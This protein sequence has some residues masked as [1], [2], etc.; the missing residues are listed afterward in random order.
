MATPAT[1]TPHGAALGLAL[2]LGA[3]APAAPKTSTVL[4]GHRATMDSLG[5]VAVGSHQDETIA[6]GQTRSHLARLRAGHCYRVVA[7][8]A[9]EG[10][11]L[12][13]AMYT[14]DGVR[15]AHSLTSGRAA[16]V[17]YC[18]ASSGT[19]RFAVSARNGQGPYAFALWDRDD[20]RSGESSTRGTCVNPLPLELGGRVTGSLVS[21]QDNAGAACAAGRN[22]DVVHVIELDRRQ[23]VQL[24]ATG[25]GQRALFVRRSCAGGGAGASNFDGPTLEC[26][27]PRDGSAA[28]IDTTLDP[29]RYY[30]FVEAV[31]DGSRGTYT[32]T[33]NEAESPEAADVCARAR[34]IEPGAVVHG[35]TEGGADVLHGSCATSRFPAPDVT[36]SLTLASAARVRVSVESESRW[37]TGVYIRSACA[38]P[39]SEVACN[40]DADDRFHAR[41]ARTLQAGRYAVTVDGYSADAHGPFTISLESSPLAGSGVTGDR[42]SDAPQINLSQKT[43]GDT[44]SARDDLALSCGGAGPDQLFRFTLPR[45]ALVRATLASEGVVNSEA[46]VALGF[47]RGCAAQGTT[48]VGESA[49]ARGAIVD[50][51]LP[52]GTHFLAVDGAT[53]NDFGQFAFTLEALDAEPVEAACR[54]AQP[55]PLGLRS[56]GTTAGRA[57]RLHASCGH[58]ARSGERAHTVTVA[59]R[60]RLIVELRARGFD[61]VLSVRAACERQ[62]TELGC[63]LENDQDLAR[64]QLD[65]EPGTYTVIVDGFDRN[66]TGAYELEARVE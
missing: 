36:Y 61:G 53:P 39:E 38:D 59:R 27:V 49:C 16:S 32:L 40:D 34:P 58:G 15:A 31:G 43:E 60:G 37:D 65:V 41:I 18:A 66:N 25:E 29:G 56:S 9:I 23:R 50:A 44:F 62:G 8:G 4:P 7:L 45:R 20:E 22:P 54:E 42:C 5:Y 55:L 63:S 47:I 11:D 13:A 30:V 26:S 48:P 33:T 21:A 57:D 64:L 24:V 3:C 10:L 51:V 19:F 35:T 6:R 12:E 1:R 46:A 2:A 28:R 14:P 17:G 52:A